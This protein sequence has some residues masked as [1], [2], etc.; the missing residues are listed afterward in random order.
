MP[1]RPR[2]YI[3]HVPAHIIQRGNNR[4]PCF[5]DSTDFQFY[6]ECLCDAV[7]KYHVAV[8][9]YVFMMTPSTPRR[10]F[11]GHSV[12]GPSLRESYQQPLPK[13]RYIVGRAPQRN[14]CRH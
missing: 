12:S 8:H 10:G 9:A 1:R 14:G 4:L 6:K 2:H 5:F 13:D 11:K 3:P 7:V